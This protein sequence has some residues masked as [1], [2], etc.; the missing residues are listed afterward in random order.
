MKSVNLAGE[1]RTKISEINASL[2][3][4]EIALRARVHNLRLQGTS[5]YIV[6]ENLTGV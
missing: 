5:L 2:D 4:S 3:G 1:K 6:Q